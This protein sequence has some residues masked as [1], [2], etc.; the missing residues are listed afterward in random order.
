M[1]ARLQSA[2]HLMLAVLCIW[3]LLLGP[4]LHAHMGSFRIGGF[5]WPGLA[6]VSLPDDTA[7]VGAMVALQPGDLLGCHNDIITISE[8]KLDWPESAVLGVGH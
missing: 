3:L 6:G 7:N 4:F 2:C 8:Q 5:H 1:L